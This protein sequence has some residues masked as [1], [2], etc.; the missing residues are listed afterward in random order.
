MD[1]FSDEVWQF[2]Q[3]SNARPGAPMFVRIDGSPK[4]NRRS[5]DF[6][7]DDKLFGFLG[8]AHG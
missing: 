4:S 7:Q 8:A 6:A 1:R 2:S 3:V 5:F